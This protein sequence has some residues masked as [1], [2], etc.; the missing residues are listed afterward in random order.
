MANFIISYDLIGPVPSHKEVDDFLSRLAARR[1][2]VLETVWWVEFGGSAADLR[3]RM[4][5]IL[6]DEDSLLVVEGTSAAWHNLLVD[7]SAFKSAWESA[8]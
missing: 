5:T 8:A 1:G 2:R 7:D 6:R 3:N 4:K